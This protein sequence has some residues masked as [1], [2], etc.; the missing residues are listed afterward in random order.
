MSSSIVIV[1][2]YRFV[3]LED[4]ESLRAP[5]LQVML[6]QKVRGTLLLAAEGINGTIAGSLCPT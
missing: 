2:L 4:F 5:L 6:D 1:A 3:R